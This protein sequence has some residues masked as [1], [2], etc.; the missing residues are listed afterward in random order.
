MKREEMI[1][2]VRLELKHIPRG[3]RGSAQNKLRLYYNGMRRHDLSINPKIPARESLKKALERLRKDYPD[4]PF[5]YN[6]EFFR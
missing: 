4:Y 5:R 2:I 1:R 3:L 6:A